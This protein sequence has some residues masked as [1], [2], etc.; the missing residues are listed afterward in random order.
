MIAAAQGSSKVIESFQYGRPDLS[1][2]NARGLSAE[3]IAK[4]RLRRAKTLKPGENGITQLQIERE[5]VTA[6]IIYSTLRKWRKKGFSA[7]LK[8]KPLADRSTQ[9]SRADSV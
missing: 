2:T 3:A 8:E 9:N 1:L 5:R 7:I 6:E 4:A